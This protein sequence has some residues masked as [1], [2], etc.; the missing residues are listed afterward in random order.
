MIISYNENSPDFDGPVLDLT[1]TTIQET[2]E[3]GVLFQKI[4][5]AKKSVWKGNQ[6]LRIPLIDMAK[7]G[8]A[9]PRTYESTQSTNCAVCG[10]RKHTPLRRDEM[11]GYVCLSCIDK[12]LDLHAFGKEKNEKGDENE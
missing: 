10:E 5:N 11:G 2:F 9:L 12:E 8:T 7:N 3:M 1:Y 6:F 4:V